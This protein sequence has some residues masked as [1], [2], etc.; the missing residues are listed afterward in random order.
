MRLFTRT[1]RA[2]YQAQVLDDVLPALQGE[3]GA[4]PCCGWFDSSHELQAGLQVTEF[5]RPQEVV[6][7]LPLGW[8]VDWACTARRSAV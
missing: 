8:W 7:A 3:D 6:N 2:E 1:P 4:A 5:E